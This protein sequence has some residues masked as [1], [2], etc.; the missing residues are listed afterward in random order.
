MYT[1]D[2]SHNPVSWGVGVKP[3]STAGSWNF[4]FRPSSRKAEASLWSW[5]FFGCQ[6]LD[7]EQQVFLP[8]KLSWDSGRGG[9]PR[10]PAI[11]QNPRVCSTWEGAN[12]PE[13][14]FQSSIRNAEN[15]GVS[16]SP[17]VIWLWFLS[18]Y[19]CPDRNHFL[20]WVS[21]RESCTERISVGELLSVLCDALSHWGRAWCG[22]CA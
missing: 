14:D 12:D 10:L 19:R 2:G 6:N 1:V 9:C 7:S 3:A 4:S 21:N 20:R 8:E 13:G 5:L 11:S 22:S 17:D 18:V 15:V 16:I